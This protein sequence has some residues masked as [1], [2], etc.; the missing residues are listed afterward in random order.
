[1]CLYFSTV[2]ISKGFFMLFLACL[3]VLSCQGYPRRKL[4]FVCAKSI[5]S[6]N[7]FKLKYITCS[8]CIDLYISLSIL[9]RANF[10][11]KLKKMWQG[12]LHLVDWF[13]FIF[14]H[15]TCL[16]IFCSFALYSQ[17]L[18]L[19]ILEMSTDNADNCTVN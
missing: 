14:L 12:G 9:S 4:W 10:S 18:R 2:F 3:S 6:L 19:Q 5:C 7:T 15:V 11:N 13:K 17:S 16:C 1:M 8:K